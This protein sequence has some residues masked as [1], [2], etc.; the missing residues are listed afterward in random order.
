MPVRVVV[1]VAISRLRPARPPRPRRPIRP[2]QPQSRTR[3]ERYVTPEIAKAKNTMVEA[4]KDTEHGW[5]R[6]M[7]KIAQSAGLTKGADGV[8]PADACAAA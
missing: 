3:I 1:L 6:A 8:Q 4:L 7:D 5:L 2:N